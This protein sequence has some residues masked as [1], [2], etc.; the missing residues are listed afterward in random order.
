M[1]EYSHPQ[2]EMPPKSNPENLREIERVI[3][4]LIIISSD[5]KILM[6]L[7]DPSKG[8]VYPDVWHIPGG[9]VDENESLTD[10]AIREGSE[11]VGIDLTAEELIASPFIGHG[12]TVKTLP[13]GE[14]VWC[15]MTFNR[16]EVHINKPSAE[17]VLHPNDDLTELRWFDEDELLAAKQVPGGKEFFIEAGYIKTES[18]IS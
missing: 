5:N 1:T 15:I 4:S 6:G 7:K 11:E 8:G 3:A 9:G 12:E 18:E 16:F 10:A 2:S 17:I 14:K 13:T